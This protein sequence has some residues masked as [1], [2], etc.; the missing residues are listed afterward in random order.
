MRSL[1]DD[2]RLYAGIATCAFI[3][4][5]IC[6]LPLRAVSQGKRMYDITQVHIPGI[7]IRCI[8]EDR[9]GFLWIG[10]QDDLVRFDSRSFKLYNKGLDF[11]TSIGGSD[12]R[13]ITESTDGIWVTSTQ[14]GLDKI[15]KTTSNP[16]LHISQSRFPQLGSRSITS[17][18]NLD[19]ILY[20]GTEQGLYSYH[21]ASD[22]ITEITLGGTGVPYVDKLASSKNHLV[23]AIRNWG[24]LSYD[25]KTGRIADSCITTSHDQTKH[26][27]FYAMAREANNQWLLG[28]SRGIN[29][30]TIN[31]S[32]QLRFQPMPFP[33]AKDGLNTDVYALDIDKSNN[34]WFSNENNLYK[35]EAGT[36]HYD[37]IQNARETSVSFLSNVYKIYCDKAG[38][39]WLCCQ[40]G[41]F[42]LK[43][44]P[45]AMLTYHQSYNS[46]TKIPHAYFL[47]PV[48][49]SIVLV[50][51]ENGLYKV[52]T[53]IRH[54]EAI[55]ETQAYD[56]VFFDPY[57]RLLVSN[58]TGL[59]QL[60]AHSLLPIQRVYPEFKPF[61]DYTINSAVKINNTHIV[62]G[63]ENYNGILIWN[64]IDHTVE[65]ITMDSKP[66]Q[67]DNNTIKTIYKIRENVFCVLTVSSLI[68]MDYTTQTSK[69]IHVPR[70]NSNEEYALFFDMCRFR[71]KYYLSSYGNGVL[72]LDTNFN[73]KNIISAEKGL[74]NNGVYKL[75]P[76][77]DSLLFM[78]TNLGLNVLQVNSDSIRHYFK[79]DGLHGDVFEETSGNILENR[80]YAGG[81]D[82]FTMI[83][84]GHLDANASPPLLY[85][86]HLT[87]DLPNK[88]IDTINTEATHFSIPADALQTNIYFSGINYINPE[89]TSYVY[90][91]SELHTNWVHLGT[92]N[93]IT[94]MGIS[95]GTYHL[96]VKAFN[97]D[98]VSGE[99]KELTLVF[100][101]RWYQTWLFKLLLILLTIGAFYGTYRIR[102][103]QL[104][105]VQNFRNK[106]ASDLHDDLGST[107]NSVKVYASLALMEKQTDKYL[108]KVKETV[109]EAITGIRDMIWV[110]DDQKDTMEHLL[111]RV[112]SF[113][114]PLCEAN[115]IA[116]KQQCTDEARDHKLGQE[117]R[118]NLYMIQ[119]E[120]INNA[121]KYA[122][123]SQ[124]TIDIIVRRSKPEIIIRDDGKGFDTAQSNDGNGLKNMARRVKEIK[125]TLRIDSTPGKGTSIHLQKA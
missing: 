109:Q 84:P 125:Y 5:V 94:L 16:A 14:G 117:E 35:I 43:N 99:L 97:E 51:A 8:T 72:V 4:T 42:F 3:M 98:A 23:V 20:I 54:I 55:D 124:I 46:I 105:Q 44:A 71:N 107:M 40:I 116:F 112:N 9:N 59:K 68:Y 1:V 28:T 11:K 21:L 91:I 39:L 76:W 75:L 83:F 57:K 19:T 87:I 24:C 86:N 103:Y 6:L 17:L 120:A 12:I 47:Q 95:P 25:L 63:T 31:E 121:I 36:S 41:L 52:N 92:R 89:R 53:N 122:A 69:R 119:K 118:R 85:I 48:N 10:T 70:N 18:L 79:S 113:G 73:I 49:D 108:Y 100:L 82:G 30:L 90:K 96:Q 2:I 61:A 38:N 67:L 66:M 56:F 15:N 27:R 65:N 114:K 26:H 101:P 34:I 33:F 22:K 106:L 58:K 32:G 115:G 111:T 50:T 77:K 80:I 29:R 7:N 45:A 60:K 110:L 64:F 104:K 78:T 81:P 102:I 37:L 123:G 74:S 93:F 13:D 88:N 62:M